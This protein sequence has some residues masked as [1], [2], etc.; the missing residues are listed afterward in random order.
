M[1]RMTTG[2]LIAAGMLFLLLDLLFVYADLTAMGPEDELPFSP[3]V[4]PAPHG[5]W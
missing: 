5:G 3:W 4:M 1:R 2:W